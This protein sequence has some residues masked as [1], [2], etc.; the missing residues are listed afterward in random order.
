ME[1]QINKSLEFKF[2][3]QEMEYLTKVYIV[4]AD[5]DLEI[6]NLEK[7]IYEGFA[8]FL[9]ISSHPKIPKDMLEKS[10]NLVYILE[11][12]GQSRIGFLEENDFVQF[13]ETI[14]T[15][16]IKAYVLELLLLSGNEGQFRS[17]I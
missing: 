16:T 12:G 1:S 14:F 13:D 9:S 10:E 15:K 5:E 8:F 2:V 17:D 3:N 6:N 11:N 7:E 4:S